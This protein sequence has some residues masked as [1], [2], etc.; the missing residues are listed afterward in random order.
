LQEKNHHI[1]LVDDEKKYNYY[2]PKC[3]DSM[4][5]PLAE[6]ISKYCKAG[7]WR[8]TQAEQAAP[9]LVI[10]KKNG[11]LHTVINAQKHNNNTVKDVT[12]FPDQDLIRLHVTRAMFHSKIDLSDMY[13]QV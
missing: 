5:K 11:K 6:K 12:P 13:E 9:M 8:P 2:L 10:P 4:R 1:P 7:W 3:P